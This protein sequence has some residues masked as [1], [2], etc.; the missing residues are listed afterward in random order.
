M[1][2]LFERAE[3]AGQFLLDKYGRAPEAAITLGSGLSGLDHILADPV[4]IAYGDIPHFPVPVVDGHAG[5]AVAGTLGSR[6]ILFLC[7]RSHIYEGQPADAVV[8]PVRVLGC[9][10]V[11]ELILTN[12][13]GAIHQDFAAGDLMRISDHINL[14]G[15]NPLAG[16]N[17]DRWG[18]RFPDQSHVYDVLLGERLSD[19]A[20]KAG[21]TLR[22]GVYAG[23]AG[24]TYETPAEVRFLRSIGADAVGMSTVAEA[25]VANHMGMRTTALSVITNKAS[26]LS[27]A[28][29]SHEEVLAV[30]K[31]ARASLEA[32]LKHYF[33]G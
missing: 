16:P 31:R 14:T 28:A 33:E 20:Q 10:G 17:E 29:L 12:A 15:L 3:E 13:A 7:G 5:L 4:S 18:S 2:T 21:I 26:G 24:P 1:G 6:A 32:I 25:I 11:E 9:M 19:A 30:G 23:V 8:F 27:D 22:E